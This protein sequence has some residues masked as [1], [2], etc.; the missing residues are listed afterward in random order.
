MITAT[1]AG[2]KCRKLTS[3][4]SLYANP[5]TDLYANTNIYPQLETFFTGGSSLSREHDRRD[6]AVRG[7]ATWGSGVIPVTASQRLQR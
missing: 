5:E 6:G 1:L 4:G 2:G 3:P 7:L